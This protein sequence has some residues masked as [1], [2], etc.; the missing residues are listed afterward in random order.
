MARSTLPDLRQL[1]QIVSLSDRTVRQS[2]RLNISIPLSLR[3]SVRMRNSVS[4]SLTLTANL[5]FLD[6]CRTSPCKVNIVVF[7]RNDENY[8]TTIALGARVLLSFL[9]SFNYNNTNKINFY[10]IYIYKINF[11]EIN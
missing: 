11:L 1:V 6:I 2:Y 3:M 8:N 4:R 7:T 9:Y 5:H 10:F